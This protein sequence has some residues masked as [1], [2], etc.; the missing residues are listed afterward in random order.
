MKN[1]EFTCDACEENFKEKTDELI[2][3]A[4]APTPAERRKRE[5]EVKAAYCSDTKH[6]TSDTKSQCGDK[7][8]DY[9][10]HAT[11]EL[12]EKVADGSKPVSK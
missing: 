4:T 1:T 8:K 2:K 12:R 10:N 6:P 5:Q 9:G 11:D 3:N 7:A